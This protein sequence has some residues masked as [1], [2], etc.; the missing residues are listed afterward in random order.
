MRS[1]IFKPLIS[2]F[3]VIAWMILIFTMSAQGRV[4]SNASSTGVSRM[5]ASVF[6]RGWNDL[7]EAEQM[8]IIESIHFWVRKAAHFTLYAVLGL[9]SF[10]AISNHISKRSLNALFAFCLCVLYAV[11]D[12][13]HQYFGDGRSCELRDVLIDSSGAIQGILI[14]Y[15]IFW[16]V[17]RKKKL[18]VES[19]LLNA[20]SVIPNGCEGS[21]NQE[22]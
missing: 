8:E 5:I 12:E 19:S 2:W 9:L 15:L 3:L 11:S 10:I 22:H 13:I 16:M 1:N 14:I 21:R 17:D 20:D 4:E 7:T 18:K 6:V